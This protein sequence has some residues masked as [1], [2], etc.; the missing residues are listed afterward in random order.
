MGSAPAFTY[1]W[2]RRL[3]LYSD[4]E[5]KLTVG[6]NVQEG[7]VPNLRV[8]VFS[9]QLMAPLSSSDSTIFYAL[10]NHGLG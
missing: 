3:R 6:N 10:E 9:L 8:V 4:D 7:N 5:D 1:S 2:G